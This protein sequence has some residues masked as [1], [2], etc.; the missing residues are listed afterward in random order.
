M[1]RVCERL[2]SGFRFMFKG[3]EEGFFW[4]EVIREV[5]ESVSNFVMCGLGCLGR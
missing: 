5:G 2:C 1:V 4:G 3:S